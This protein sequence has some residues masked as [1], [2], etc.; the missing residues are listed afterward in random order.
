[1]AFDAREFREKTPGCAWNRMLLAV[2]QSREKVG[3]LLKF[4]PNQTGGEALFGFLEPAITKMIESV[5]IL[6]KD[7]TY[8]LHF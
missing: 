7:K 1:M 5:Y 8:I 6:N 4:F 2:M 3:N